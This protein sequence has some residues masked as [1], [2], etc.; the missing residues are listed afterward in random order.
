MLLVKRKISTIHDFWV[1]SK[2]LK[3]IFV[4]FLKAHNC[5]ITEGKSF[6]ITDKLP[7]PGQKIV[8]GGWRQ[9]Q[10]FVCKFILLLRITVV[11][12]PGFVLSSFI[13][14]NFWKKGY[15][16]AKH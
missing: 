14:V 12:F 8:K 5:F 13:I 7:F 9:S 10:I 4:P 6:P 2:D 11:G 1:T 16:L 15:G 3:I